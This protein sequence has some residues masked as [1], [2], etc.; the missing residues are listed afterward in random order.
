MIRRLLVANRGEIAV[1]VIRACRELGVE[2][3]AVYSEPDRHALHVRLADI[4]VSIGQAPATESYLSMA[5]LVEAAR[6]TRADA[7]HPGYG[8]LAEN[9][10]FA[11]ACEKAGLRFVGPPAPVIAQMGSKIEARAR[12][13]EAGLPIVPGETPETQD[14]ASL[15]AAAERVGFPLLVKAAAGGGGKGMRVVHARKELA[16]A[17]ASARH[18]AAGAFGDATLYLERLLKKPSHVEVQVFGDAAGQ[19]VH[20]FERDCS[21]QRRHQK[22]IEESP[23]PWLSE[24]LRRRMGEAAVALARHIAYRNAGTIEFLVEGRGNDARFYFLEMNT[25]LQ[26]EHPVTEAV[27]GMDLV[28]AQLRVAS[29]EALPWRQ[30]S[31]AQRG[32]AIECRIYAEDPATDF[33]PQAGP[34]T[35]YREPQ[36]PGIRVDSGV[37]EGDE[38]SIYYDPLLAKLIASGES[39]ET[40]R[41]RMLA[42]LRQ[43]AVLGTRTNIPFLIRVLEH[44]RFGQAG[45]DTSFLD[46]EGHSLCEQAAGPGLPAAL[47]AAAAHDGR[48]STRAGGAPAAEDPWDR[49]KGWRNGQG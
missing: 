32:H 41:G 48:G 31:L 36:G 18:E 17:F 37:V 15:G 21:I 44:D 2:T 3:V 35:V 46:R 13:V 49:L 16:E 8:F 38:V 47:A 23:A 11:A 30:E 40:A 26:V 39:R 25:R 20:L 14:D 43:F 7:V 22:I 28:Q 24:G 34:L 12:A 10:G 29:G 9:A 4:A 19:V 33:L 45:I 27:V 5:R 6:N 1:R 42:A